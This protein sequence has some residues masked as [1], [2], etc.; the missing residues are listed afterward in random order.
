LAA[1][2]LYIT[3]GILILVLGLLAWFYGGYH[4][5]TIDPPTLLE[6]SLERMSRAE[7]FRYSLKSVLV[8]SSRK[9][10]I[11]EI[12][13]A[14]AAGG[15]HITGQMVKTPVDI[16]YMDHT[17]YNF[18]AIS[19]RWLVIDDASSSMSQI[20][21]SELSPLSNFNFKSVDTVKLLGFEKLDGR[22]YAILSCRPSVENELLEVYW[23]D[24]YYRMWIDPDSRV[25]YRAEMTAVSKHNPQTELVLEV[26]F[27]DLGKPLSI[28]KPEV[29]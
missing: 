2:F 27:R 24:F 29:E 16:Y 7:S 9:E 14:K 17:T 15:V 26:R 10:V 19:R 4:K 22:R 21:V 3:G 11:S 13:G 5:V 18:D 28:K 8:V 6:Q 25:L 1:I 23:K 12:E 20:L